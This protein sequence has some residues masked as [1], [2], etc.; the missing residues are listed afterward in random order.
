M[1]SLNPDPALLDELYILP[2]VTVPTLDESALKGE[3]EQLERQL[4][5]AANCVP[6][7]QL[8]PGEVV[9]GDSPKHPAGQAGL[10]GGP[11][12]ISA[13]ATAAGVKAY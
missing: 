7:P 9:I 5:L 2:N 13:S 3:E 1:Q 12:L 6:G 11:V 8:K 4:H 10:D